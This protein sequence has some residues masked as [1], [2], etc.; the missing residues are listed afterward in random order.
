MRAEVVL[1]R[2]SARFFALFLVGLVVAFWPSYC[3]WFL[4]LPL[5]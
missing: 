3:G 4:G 1:H 2:N 5:S